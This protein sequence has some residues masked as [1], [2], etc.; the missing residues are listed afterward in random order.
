MR[1][2]LDD[3]YD[4]AST[5]ARAPPRNRGDQLSGGEQQ[6]VA[7][8]R[9]LLANPRVLLVDEPSEGSR[10]SSSIG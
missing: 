9:A 8:G 3:V 1:W 7:I 5:F 2:S 10:R 4:A 6:M